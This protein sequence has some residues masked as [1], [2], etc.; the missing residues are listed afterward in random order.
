MI[1][2]ICSAPRITLCHIYRLIIGIS[3]VFIKFLLPVFISN[4]RVH[5]HWSKSSDIQLIWRIFKIIGNSIWCTVF[6]IFSYQIDFAWAIICSIPQKKIIKIARWILP[7]HKFSTVFISFFCCFC[8]LADHCKSW[9]LQFCFQTFIKCRQIR[10][11]F[12]QRIIC[13]RKTFSW[14]MSYIGNIPVSTLRIC[15]II[16]TIMFRSTDRIVISLLLQPAFWIQ[17]ILLGTVL[18]KIKICL[19][20]HFLTACRSV[21][22]CNGD[23]LIF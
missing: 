6:I 15:N 21:F 3:I 23:L 4:I 14:R 18:Q 8:F 5:G 11:V 1:R 2:K 22:S 7:Y 13:Y 10:T 20:Y 19:S 16:I 9:D 17:Y 12:F